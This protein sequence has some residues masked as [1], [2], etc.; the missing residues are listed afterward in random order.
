MNTPKS[1]K[2]HPA[3]AASED[4]REIVCSNRRARHEYDILEELDCGIVLSGSEVKSIRNHKISIEEA[5]ARVD[6]EE[7]WLVDCDIAEYAQASV[8]NHA[9]Q[10][11]RK[12]LL[13]RREIRKFAETA[14]HDGLTLVPL[15]VFFQRGLVK[16][17]L[18]LCKGRKVHDKRQKLK[19]Q[20][21]RR[22]MRDARMKKA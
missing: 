2:N 1:G 19:E 9:R 22:E 8:L 11:K 16:I 18:G 5:Y 15:A 4:A 7:V 12:L 17:R 10:R 3:R 21:D 6:Q 13:R 14:E 20:A